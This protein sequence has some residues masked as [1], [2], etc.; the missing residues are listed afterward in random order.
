MRDIMLRQHDKGRGAAA[1]RLWAFEQILD[2]PGSMVDVSGRGLLRG[3]PDEFLRRVD[4]L[5][6]FVRDGTVPA[7]GR[8]DDPNDFSQQDKGR[9]SVLQTTDRLFGDSIEKGEDQALPVERFG[10][11]SSSVAGVAAATVGGAGSGGN[12]AARV[13]ERAP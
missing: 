12:V 1:L 4:Q 9:V 3:D 7:G 13:E 5:V 8:P 2:L 11:N 6:R 10:H